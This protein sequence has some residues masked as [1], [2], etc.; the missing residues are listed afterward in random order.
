MRAYHSRAPLAESKLAPVSTNSSSELQ[1]T[2]LVD[3]MVILVVFLLMSFSADDQIIIPTDGIRLPSSSS[4]TLPEPG[5]V[6]QVG[7]DTINIEGHLIAYSP[8]ISK[9]THEELAPLVSALST[10]ASSQ[11]TNRV[12]IQADRQIQY[13][14]LSHVLQAC[15]DAGLSNVS[16]VVLGGGR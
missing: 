4:S 13:T 6:L 12:L 15:A 3:M 2:S 16:L 8:S 10:A 1:M 14:R 7:L 11:A 5:I 9:P